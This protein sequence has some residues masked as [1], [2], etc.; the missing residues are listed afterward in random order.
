MTCGFFLTPRWGVDAGTQQS[1][2]FIPYLWPSKFYCC[3]LIVC[4]LEWSQTNVHFLS[5]TKTIQTPEGRLQHLR[6]LASDFSHHVATVPGCC[7][8]TE[9]RL[10]IAKA[11]RTA[12][13]CKS[14]AEAQQLCLRPGKSFHPVCSDDLKHSND[15]NLHK[16]LVGII[17]A[18]VNHQ[19]SRCHSKSQEFGLD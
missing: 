1:S 7:F 16:C 4:P 19:A 2:P 15:E 11:S 12:L 5:M 17:H 10:K 18:V 6:N 8:S 14:C 9:T 13:F 3:D